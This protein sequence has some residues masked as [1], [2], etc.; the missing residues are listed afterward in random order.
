MTASQTT[1]AERTL[2]EIAAFRNDGDDRG[3]KFKGL[4]GNTIGYI[5]IHAT[6]N[7]GATRGYL[8]AAVGAARGQRISAFR[9]EPDGYVSK[10]RAALPRDVLLRQ[11]VR[12][13]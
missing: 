6:Q 4:D 5:E 12:S 9:I 8:I 13:K 3:D 2:R 1:A 7:D 10:S 11:T